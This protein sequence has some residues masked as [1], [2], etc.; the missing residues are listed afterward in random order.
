M[1]LSFIIRH[2]MYTNDSW[3]HYTKFIADFDIEKGAA[4]RKKI[5][6]YLAILGID[7]DNF[8]LY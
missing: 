2:Y 8:L 7:Y 6:A 5:R 1:R 4:P 3:F